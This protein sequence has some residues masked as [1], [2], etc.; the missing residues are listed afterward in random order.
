RAE[1]VRIPLE[2]ALELLHG[3]ARLA[4]ELIVSAQTGDEEGGARIPLTRQR[5][6]GERLVLAPQAHEVVGVPLARDGIAGIEV[7]GPPE[8]TTR[9]LPLVAE[10]HLIVGESR[11]RL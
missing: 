7:D 8:R 1:E 3:H 5:R 4:H 11:V 2:G 10:V 9:L 6:F